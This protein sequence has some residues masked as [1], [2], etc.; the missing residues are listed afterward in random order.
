ML[1]V[2]VVINALLMAFELASVAALAW[3][4][5]HHP[6]IFAAVTGSLAFLI[7]LQLDFA[8][9]RH[10]YPFYFDRPAPRSILGLRAIASV[11][12]LLKGLAAA[13]IALITFSSADG[14]RVQIVAVVFAVVTYFGVSV[15]RRLSVSFG[16]RPLRWG[17]FRLA[18]PLGL[19][20]SVGMAT[21][22]AFG[23]VRVPTLYDL[24][25]QIVF[26][27][28]E[29]PGIDALSDLLF[30]LKQYV[31]SLIA[32]ALNTFMPSDWAQIVGLILSVNVLTGFVIAVYAVI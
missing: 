28:P 8:R 11:D 13:A 9:L 10:E 5:M 21:L 4:A 30:N 27:T 17:F 29:R 16:A 2:R 20:F 22:A 3:V 6:Y 18:V 25:R 23:Y 19:V 32:T 15:L 31:D 1:I 24:G 12:S 7:G 26:E 14:E